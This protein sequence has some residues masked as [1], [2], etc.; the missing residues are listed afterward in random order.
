LRSTGTWLEAPFLVRLVAATG[1]EQ[2]IVSEDCRRLASSFAGSDNQLLSAAAAGEAV[3]HQ[4]LTVADRTYY[5]AYAP[6]P[7]SGEESSLFSET[8]LAVDDVIAT[9]RNAFFILAISTATVILL[10]SLFRILFVRQ[11]NAPLEELTTAADLLDRG[12][13]TTPIPLF[14]APAEVKTL[15]EAL[16]RSQASMLEAL[17]E[18]SEAGKRLNAILQ[19]VV[20]GVVTYNPQGEIT[21]W[22]E[23]ASSFYPPGVRSRD[24]RCGGGSDAKHSH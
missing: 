19:S 23:G 10:G 11:V 5:M 15:S 21:F 17:R 20:E 12:Y 8:A 13:L 24:W 18:S 22:S 1:V 7:G 9:E 3:P 2:S 16:Y 6:V 14:P 4:T